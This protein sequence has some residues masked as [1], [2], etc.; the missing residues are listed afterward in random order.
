MISW[1]SSLVLDL[2]RRRAVLVLGAGVSRNSTN[3][4][5]ERP[6]LWKDFLTDAIDAVAS[7]AAYKKA[8]R[9][10]VK[11][12]DYLT[13][14]EMIKQK[15]GTNPFH[16]FV[17]AKFLTPGFRHAAV[18]DTIIQLDARIVA[19]PNID[20]IYE[21]RINAIQNNS[22]LVKTY[23]E[24]DVAEAVRSPSRIVLKIH[25]TVHNAS[26]MIF[27]RTEYANARHEYRA[28]YNIVEALAI[29]HTFLF[30]G[31]GL[32]DPDIRLL[33]ED[34]AFRHEFTPPHFFV[35]SKDAV[36]THSVRAIEESMN[37]KLLLYDPV[38]SH[39]VLA[40]SL[41]DL[42]QRVEAKRAALT[43]ADW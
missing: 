22:V 35:L 34:Y 27:T 37:V 13:A 36:N 29:T 40:E 43:A 21:N 6:C 30:I 32:A 3:A 11:G 5:G 8:I 15:M 41:S 38:D 23:Y 28:F 14:C 17:R 18:H 16:D 20:T 12:G 9:Q 26:K 4:A 7:S 39:R 2:S 42:V 33:L 10:L 31:C 1:P 25:G 24:G 19:T